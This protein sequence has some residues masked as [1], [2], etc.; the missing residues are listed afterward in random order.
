MWI[1]YF[2]LN[3]SVCEFFVKVRSEKYNCSVFIIVSG[4]VSKRRG[5]E[6]LG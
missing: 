2:V 6:C 4:N 5:G 3:F 1:S